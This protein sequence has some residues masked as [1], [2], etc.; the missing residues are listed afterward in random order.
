M[1]KANCR[2]KNI[3]IFCKAWMGEPADTNFATG[4]SEF[5]KARGMCKND[6]EMHFPNELC[7]DFEK[8]I[9]YL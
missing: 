1:G 3:C 9:L 5:S 4:M 6:G 7:K 2:K 8:S